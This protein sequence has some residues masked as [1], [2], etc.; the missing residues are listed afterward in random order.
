MEI[1]IRKLNDE[2]FE[3]ASKM[4]FHT[5]YKYILPTYTT[6]GVEFFRDT[7]SPMSFRMNTFDGSITLYGA[8]LENMLCGVLGCRGTN[9]ICLFFTH[10][11]YMG[12]GIGRRLFSHFLS[13]TDKREPVTV[14]ASDYGVPVYQRLGF[15]I[16]DLRKEEN[17]VVYTP[18]TYRRGDDE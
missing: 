4:I 3:E 8:Y 18:M 1:V 16:T 17:G 9:H 15:E 5:F 6:E 13:M 7:T 14:N 12:R 11:D 10:K 2:D